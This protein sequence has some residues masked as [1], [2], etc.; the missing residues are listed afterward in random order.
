MKQIKLLLS[1][2]LLLF[3]MQI[4]AQKFEGLALT[5]PMGW[6]SWNHF[7]CE[8]NE[9]IIKG[10]ADEM[11]SNGMRDAGYE[12][13]NIDDCWHGER[14]S[15]GFIHP[16][17]EHFP[18]GMKAL[19]DY[20]HS[21]GLK[22]GIYSDAGWKTCGG[23][24]GSRGHEYQDAMQYAKWGIDYLKYDW[25][26]TDGLKA[27]G[28]YLTMREALRAAGRPIVL[29]ICEW[30]DNSPWFWAT[31]IGH[32]WRTTGD[33][34]NCF[35]CEYDHGSWSSW[36]VLQIIDQR[37]NDT[38]RKYAGPDHWNDP[39]MMEIGNGMSVNEDRAHFSMWCM[40]AAPLIAGNDLRK[41]NAETLEILTNKEAIAVDQDALG[42]QGFKYMSMDSVDVWV[43][44]LADN[45]LAICFLN[46]GKNNAEIEFNWKENTIVDDLK[47][48]TYN[49]S[50]SEYTLRDLWL[51]EDIGKTSK[52]LKATV[53]G[54]DVLMLRLSDI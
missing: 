22:L 39:D 8:I 37:D 31:D 26:F 10:V 48:F 35:D 49:F 43:K 16:S 1:I 32:L 14:D 12:Y 11:A 47:G 45:D 38:L 52:P 5:P 42:I 46:K 33:I 36:G 54:Y 53:P 19:S 17:P 25:C 15:L 28:T 51:K 9:D 40:L 3:T 29:S 44:P 50:E 2:V 18:S 21:K 13:I 4:G 6:N 41:M 30:G 34:Y 20:V 27:E 23:H 24:P 7:A